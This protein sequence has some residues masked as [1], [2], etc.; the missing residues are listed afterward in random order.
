[1]KETII[2]FKR[3][4]D[5]LKKMDK[6]SYIFVKDFVKEI[7][8]KKTD[9]LI[10]TEDNEKYFNMVYITKRRK[11]APD[12]INLA[13]KE[14]YIDPKDN[15]VTEEFLEFNKEKYKKTIELSYYDN[16]GHIGGAYIAPSKNT[17][18]KYLNTLKK[19]TNLQK[20]Y[21]LKEASYWIGGFGDSSLIKPDDGY[22]ITFEILEE[23]LK[24]GWEVIDDKEYFSDKE[25]KSKR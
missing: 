9:F 4:F 25:L 23:I 10:F 15:P 6:S 12:L 20:K 14:I 19:I 18:G 16:Y 7:K 5:L 24:D 1:M 13:I 21:K 22:E 3:R 11:N 2:D 17:E 8:M